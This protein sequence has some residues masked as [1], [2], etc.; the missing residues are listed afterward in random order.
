MDLNPGGV[1]IV[2][3]ELQKKVLIEICFHLLVFN[4]ALK[5]RDNL[6]THLMLN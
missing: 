5:H 1:R 3:N 4:Q 2:A 6:L